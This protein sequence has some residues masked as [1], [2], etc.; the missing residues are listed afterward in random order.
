[1]EAKLFRPSVQ[2]RIMESLYLAAE[3]G[4]VQFVSL[5]RRRFYNRVCF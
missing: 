3:Y 4:T 1:M 5:D 2:A